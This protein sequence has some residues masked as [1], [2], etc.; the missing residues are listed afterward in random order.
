MTTRLRACGDCHRHFRVTDANC[1][2]CAAPGEPGKPARPRV[3]GRLSRAQWFALTSSLAVVG[4]VATRA[5]RE[6][7]DDLG[8]A[9]SAAPACDANCYTC[10]WPSPQGES[11]PPAVSCSRLHQY[12]AGDY[13]YSCMALD[14]G[15]FAAM[16]AKAGAPCRDRPTCA[17][18]G[19]DRVPYQQ[20]GIECTVPEGQDC[21]YVGCADD[22]AGG[23]SLEY[24]VPCYGAPPARLA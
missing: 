13:A 15:P 2:F 9:V 11:L 4:C 8:T 14:A 20:S 23:V 5:V 7:G 12:C 17:C 21:E 18:L 24:H 10:A 1:P 22:D 3:P 6:T 16:F 19:L